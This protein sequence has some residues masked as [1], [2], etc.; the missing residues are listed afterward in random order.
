MRKKLVMAVAAVAIVAGGFAGW[1]W[2]ADWRFVETTD[3]AYVAGDIV[4][5]ASKVAGRIASVRVADNQPVH[6]GDVLM[7][8]DDADYRAAA[9]Q[10]RA[11]LAAAIAAVEVADGNIAVEKTA[12]VEAEAALSSAE[13]ERTRAG[14]DL[15]RYR[16]LSE[17]Q[18]ASTQK[19]Q[20]AQAD[21]RKAV[22][23]VDQAAAAVSTQKTRLALLAAQRAQAVAQVEEAKAALA[24]AQIRLDDTV[25]RTPVDGVVGNKGAQVGQYAQPGQQEMSVV[26][27]RALYVSANFKETQLSR[28]RVGQPV[29]IEFDAYRGKSFHGTVDSLSPGSGAVFSLL[30]PENATGNFTK[31]VQ[32]VPVKIRLSEDARAALLVPGMSVI[33]RVDTRGEAA[34]LSAASAFAPQEDRAAGTQQTADRPE[35]P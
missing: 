10:A 18:Y 33:A 7:T 2:Y 25:I 15:A 19:Y 24:A 3:N 35:R 16:T 1:K 23:A 4:T 27:V 28:M 14:A 17:S 12:I 34:P 8:I 30:P 11:A 13:A 31:I 20:S 29:E 22:A 32:R 26:P 5:I 9:E 6:A 21:A